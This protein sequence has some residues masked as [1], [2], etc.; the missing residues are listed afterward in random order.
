[1][2]LA[3][4]LRK[5]VSPLVNRVQNMLGKAVLA[6]VTDSTGIQ[7]LKVSGLDEEVLDGVEHLQPF[8]FTANCPPEG[9]SV[10]LGFIGGNREHPVALV[11]DNGGLRKKD[12]EPGESA[13]YSAFG[14]FIHLDKDGRVHVRGSD[15]APAARQGD[16][17][18]LTLSAADVAALGAAIAAMAIFVPTGTPPAPATPVILQDGEITGGSS[19]V[20]II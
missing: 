18:K 6:A 2:T 14:T 1:M 16:A 3:D 13:Q 19:A 20:Q 15:G 12:L 4:Q 5:F 8:G 10:F 7:I 17:V 9:S 11:A